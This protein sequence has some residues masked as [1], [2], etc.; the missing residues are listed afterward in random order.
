MGKWKSLVSRNVS[1]SQAGFSE[2]HFTENCLIP[3]FSSPSNQLSPVS[4]IFLGQNLP[5]LYAAV[6][7]P[8]KER[9]GAFQK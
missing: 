8:D 1:K 5:V 2:I 7:S 3:Q 4:Q 9:E 6:G